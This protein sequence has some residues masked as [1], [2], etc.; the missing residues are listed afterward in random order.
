VISN[1]H[2]R[3]TF[4]AAAFAAMLL[5]LWVHRGG[6]ALAPTPRDVAGDALWASMVAW[7]IS[8]ALP[9]WSV[10]L[11]AGIAFLICSAVELSQLLHTPLLDAWRATTLGQLIL[12]SGFDVRDLAAYAAG[13]ALAIVVERTW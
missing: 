11:R 13:I 2:D 1:L 4:I 8:A 10:R 6:L 7:G 3:L 9:T 12:G 5:G